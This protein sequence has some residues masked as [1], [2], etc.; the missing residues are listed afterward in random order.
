MPAYFPKLRSAQVVEKALDRI[1]ANDIIGCIVGPPG[2]G[3]SLPLRHW[4][5]TRNI[6]HILITAT[7]GGSLTAFVHALAEGVNI[8]VSGGLEATSMRIANAL[9]ADPTAVIVEEADFL[10][11]PALTRA[12]A[13]WDWAQEVRDNDEGRAFPLAFIG[14]QALRT[15]LQRDEERAEQILRRVGQFDQVPAMDLQEV[16][17]I[18]EAKWQLDGKHEI[19][20]APGAVEEFKRL[21]KGSFG[22]LNKIV[23]LAIELARRDGKVITTTLVK[24]TSRNLVGV[25]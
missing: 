19:N 17:G 13:I 25:E 4:R 18:L 24:A 14:T 1:V 3:K 21:S 23:P 22:W 2:V 15:K 9:A 6:P 20:L 7:M 12:R 16:A 5:R 11:A 10:Q 8:T